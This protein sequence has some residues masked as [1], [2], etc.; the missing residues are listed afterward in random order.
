MGAGRAPG[1]VLCC[2]ATNK[3]KTK[4]V[5]RVPGGGR[6][7]A[8]RMPVPVLGCNATKYKNEQ[9]KEGVASA[10]RVPG[11]CLEDAGVCVVL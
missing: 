4:S 3:Y 1:L 11:E 2:S 9:K 7:N 8:W 10:G 5:A 6:E